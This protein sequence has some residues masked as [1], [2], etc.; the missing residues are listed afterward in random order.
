MNHG[1]TRYAEIDSSQVS[2][3][4]ALVITQSPANYS[5]QYAWIG[6][7]YYNGTRYGI[8]AS[9]LEDVTDQ[10]DADSGRLN[11][12]LPSGTDGIEYQVFAYYETRSTYLEQAS[13]MHL[14][15]TVVQSPVQSYVENGSW[16][17]DHFS[18]KV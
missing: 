7:F 8:A 18:S 14:N 17:V 15:T 6:P 4:T 16:V 2:A 9:S 1:H 13:P 11:L 10:V 12:Q 5:A 3:S